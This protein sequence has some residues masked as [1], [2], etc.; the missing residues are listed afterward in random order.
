[1]QNSI[2]A[3]SR[4]ILYIEDTEANVSLMRFVLKRMKGVTLLHAP[5]AELGI[6]MAIKEHPGLILMDIDLPGM[7]GIAALQVLRQNQETCDIPVIAISG[8]VVTNDIE[9]IK[10]ASFNAFISKPFKVQEIP[11]TIAKYM[12]GAF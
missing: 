7:N 6:P 5:T 10:A 4:K 8:A 12:K 9:N 2:N 3:Q 1:M 11:A